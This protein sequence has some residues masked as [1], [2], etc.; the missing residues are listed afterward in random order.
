MAST[1]EVSAA[2]NYAAGDFSDVKSVK[3][4]LQSWLSTQRIECDAGAM[5][6]ALTELQGTAAQ[7]AGTPTS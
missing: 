1:A 7:T 6:E 4:G 3:A 2:A 5:A